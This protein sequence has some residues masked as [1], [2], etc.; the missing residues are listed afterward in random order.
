MDRLPANK[1]AQNIPLCMRNCS[2]G[3]MG[4]RRCPVGELPSQGQDDQCG[5]LLQHAGQREAVL[6]NRPA[7]L[8]LHVIILHDN[9]KSSQMIKQWF[10]Q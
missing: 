9:V 1:E 5:T 3:L 2:N 4:C 8:N 10:K 7:W 6:T